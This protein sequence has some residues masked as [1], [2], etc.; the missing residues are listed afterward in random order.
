MQELDSSYLSSHYAIVMRCAGNCAPYPGFASETRTIDLTS[1][2]G[3]PIPVSPF[4]YLEFAS[5]SV[6]FYIR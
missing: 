4:A 5:D 6:F 3:D 1:D 2:R